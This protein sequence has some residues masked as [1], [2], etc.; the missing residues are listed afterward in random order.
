M[1]RDEE[2]GIT[3]EGTIDNRL[4]T[5]LVGVESVIGEEGPDSGSR[6]MGFVM[7]KRGELGVGGA[8][9]T[10]RAEMVD[11]GGSTTHAEGK[12]GPKTL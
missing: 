2:E 12:M 3:A 10:G 7:V 1:G 11:D 6:A 8:A 4:G 9:A 5:P